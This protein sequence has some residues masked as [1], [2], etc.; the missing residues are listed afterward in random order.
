MHHVQ[1]LSRGGAC[2]P[3][4]SSLAL[5]IGSVALLACGGSDDSAGGGTASSSGSVASAPAA[6]KEMPTAAEISAEARQ[7]LDLVKAS[8]YAEAISPCEKALEDS[9]SLASTDVQAALDEA[10]GKLEE[11]AQ[12]AALQAA[13]D[14]M[15]GKDPT[16]SAKESAMGALQGL[17]GD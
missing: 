4:A 9:A 6:K 17:G 10:K 11:E 13:A 12:K 1:R 16:A 7:C 3:T 2:G 8:R 5:L 14:G 15:S